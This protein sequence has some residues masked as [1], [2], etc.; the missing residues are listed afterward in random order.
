MAQVGD[1]NVS[2]QVL[3]VLKAAQS[4]PKSRIEKKEVFD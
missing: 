4:K 1:A 2:P 3:R